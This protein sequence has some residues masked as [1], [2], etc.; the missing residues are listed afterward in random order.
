[1]AISAKSTKPAI[2]FHQG[3]LCRGRRRYGRGQGQALGL[4]VVIA[5][6]R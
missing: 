2:R 6:L 3:H 1:M 5:T 4:V